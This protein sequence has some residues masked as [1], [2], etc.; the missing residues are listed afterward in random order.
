MG[1]SS[2]PTG[3]QRVFHS[4]PMPAWHACVEQDG[5]LVKTAGQA[6]NAVLTAPALQ[7]QLGTCSLGAWLLVD[8]QCSLTL[9]WC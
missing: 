1:G 3:V 4:S 2:R 6:F 5:H 7:L 8:R 9:L